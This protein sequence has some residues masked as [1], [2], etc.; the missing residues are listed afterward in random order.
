MKK[1]AEQHNL[2]CKQMEPGRDC[3][4]VLAQSLSALLDDLHYAR[5]AGGGSSK[6]SWREHRDLHFV[7]GLRPANE[8]IEIVERKR[9]QDFRSELHFAMMQIVLAQDEAQRLNR[10]KITAAGIAENVAPAAGIL[11]FVAA[12]PGHRGAAS[13]T[14]HDSVAMFEG[15]RKPGFPI[16]AGDDSGGGPDFLPEP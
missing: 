15:S 4:C 10:E 1:S 8:F 14:D 6:N 13:C 5:I 11:D 2:G 7:G 16:A 3:L 12:A 9:V